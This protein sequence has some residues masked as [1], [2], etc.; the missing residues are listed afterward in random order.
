MSINNDETIVAIYH[1]FQPQALDAINPEYYILYV[2]DH[3][4]MIDREIAEKIYKESILPNEFQHKDLIGPFE[5]LDE[6]NKF[7][8]LLCESINAPRVSLMSVQDYNLLLENSFDT[9][10]FL[11]DLKTKGNILENIDREE[12]KKSGFFSK[13]FK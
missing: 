9:H 8:F 6:L 7:A 11:N 13:I 10:N 3:R 2:L 12:N 5:S 4:G 1:Y